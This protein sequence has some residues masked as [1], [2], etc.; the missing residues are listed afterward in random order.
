M[1]NR[2]NIDN[3]TKW[4]G[5]KINWHRTKKKKKNRSSNET[6][7]FILYHS[8][9]SDE[10]V[11]FMQIFFSFS[12]SICDSIQKLCFFSLCCHLNLLSVFI[13]NWR[14]KKEKKTQWKHCTR[15][16]IMKFCEKKRKKKKMTK[17]CKKK[18]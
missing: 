9:T 1:K 15:N 2:R 7:H 6:T 16:G 8:N 11:Q 3:V 10:I 13:R 12:A 14:K 18:T 5:K 17:E 4:N